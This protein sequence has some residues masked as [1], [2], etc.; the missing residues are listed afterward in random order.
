MREQKPDEDRRDYLLLVCMSF[1]DDNDL[2]PFVV[3]YDDAMFDGSCLRDDIASAL[4]IE[5]TQ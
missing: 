1:I 4:D 3:F 2:E 5:A